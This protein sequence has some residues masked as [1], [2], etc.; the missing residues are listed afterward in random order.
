MRLFIAAAAACLLACSSVS[1]TTWYLN[2]TGPSA[3][4]QIWALDDD[5]TPK[6]V[7]PV[8]A[9]PA[10]ALHVAW[11]S[12]IQ[13]GATIRVYASAY[14]GGWNVVR[15]WTSSDGITFTDQGTVFAADTSEPY[16]VGPA[17][18]TYDPSLAT[19]W[20][21]FYLVR[22]A[23]GPGPSIAVATS[24]DGITWAR[25]GVVLTA[26]LPEEAGGLSMTYACRRANGDY[27]M[28]Y[29]GYSADHSKGVALI[30]EASSPTQ[31]FTGKTIVKTFDGFT[32]TIT[33]S[34]GEN[35][36]TVPSGVTV[37]LGIPLL[38]RAGGTKETIVAKRQDGT[39]VWFDRP[40]LNSYS[41][42]ELHSMA[43]NKVDLSYIREMPDGT[44]TG[45][46]TVYGPASGV[47]AEY[48]TEGAASS[49][50]SPWS[51][52]GTGLRF[53][54]WLPA[55]ASS[56]ENPVPLVSHASCAN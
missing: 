5:G 42:G 36:G 21:L 38:A 22:S 55:T 50:T 2:A 8:I 14:I 52:T 12:A 53:T 16:G 1:A 54:P 51:Y 44:W 33:G 29:H 13:V 30:A 6:T 43:R 10:G 56:M 49:L 46:F 25:Q 35:T 23:S 17:H 19:P 4:Y 45:I 48:T 3:P 11:P 9:P 31:P 39:R 34:A 26:S 37:S 27:V 24:A 28:V 18:V 41:A 32:T 15:L 40:L 20:S 7:A 47:L